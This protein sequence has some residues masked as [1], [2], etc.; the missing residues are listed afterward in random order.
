L[1]SQPP[2]IGPKQAL[3]EG[4]SGLGAFS[5]GA[6]LLPIAVG[7]GYGAMRIFMVLAALLLALG[8]GI[9]AFSG[10]YWTHVSGP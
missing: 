5:P 1:A 10:Y 6:I 8:I 7:K 2:Q 4:I 3:Q 9:V